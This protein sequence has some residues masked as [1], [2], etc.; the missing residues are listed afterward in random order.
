MSSVAEMKPTVQEIKRRLED[1]YEL[2][3]DLH[4]QISHWEAVVAAFEAGRRAS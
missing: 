2:R 1:M 4:R 3:E